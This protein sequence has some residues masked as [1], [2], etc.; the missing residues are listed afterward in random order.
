MYE[1]PALENP[2]GI[3]FKERYHKHT[4]QAKKKTQQ[5]QQKIIDILVKIT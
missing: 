1:L 5:Q 3:Y 2:N 4:F